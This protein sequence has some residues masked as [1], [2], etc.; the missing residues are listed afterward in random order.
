M[1][2]SAVV[3]EST[4]EVAANPTVGSAA[5]AMHEAGIARRVSRKADV[6]SGRQTRRGKSQTPRSLDGRTEGNRSPEAHRRSHR[7]DGQ[8]VTGP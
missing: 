4:L 3:G 5:F 8:R 1:R 2:V 6:F 7:E